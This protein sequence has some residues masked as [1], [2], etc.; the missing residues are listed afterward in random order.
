MYI[1]GR[2]VFTCHETCIWFLLWRGACVFYSTLQNIETLTNLLKD[3]I[4]NFVHALNPMTSWFPVL[5]VDLRILWQMVHHIHIGLF[6]LH[7]LF[8]G[9]ASE[10][11]L[12]FVGAVVQWAFPAPLPWLSTLS[13]CGV[14]DPLCQTS[15]F[16]HHIGPPFWFLSTIFSFSFCTSSMTKR[17]KT[18]TTGFLL[19]SLPCL[20]VCHETVLVSPG[21]SGEFAPR[22]PGWSE[23]LHLLRQPGFE[24]GCPHPPPCPE[25][26][27]MPCHQVP[28][29][30]WRQRS[31][32][33]CDS[34]TFHCPVGL[35]R[36]SIQRAWYSCEHHGIPACPGSPWW[37]SFDPLVIGQIV[38]SW[39]R[40]GSPQ[41]WRPLWWAPQRICHV[42]WGSCH[43][44]H[45]V[46]AHWCIRLSQR[47]HT[48]LGAL[49][50]AFPRKWVFFWTLRL[51]GHDPGPH[52]PPRDSTRY[53]TPSRVFSFE[54]WSR[55]TF[56]KATPSTNNAALGAKC[57]MCS[58]G[59]RSLRNSSFR[60]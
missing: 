59:H 8:H 47:G 33:L 7:R 28:R 38:G 42:D 49:F 27:R 39:H 34:M 45:P 31:L 6:N 3:L 4:N 16:H 1:M 15:S 55:A 9:Q 54:A 10:R 35:G 56:W 25:P 29:C 52:C 46:V 32:S 24:A 13:T 2:C 11:A 5:L 40:P 44:L 37:S 23:H 14:C 57:S 20:L 50:G 43:W 12:V 58:A 53:W 36:T 17:P 60:A 26:R 48:W 30:S 41:A 18:S 19:Q 21:T 51:T 22:S